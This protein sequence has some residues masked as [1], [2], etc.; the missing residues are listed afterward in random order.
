MKK[1][2]L[3]A[4]LVCVIGY[5]CKTV[6]LTGRKQF[7]LIPDADITAMSS[8]QYKQ[9]IQ[10]GP[11]STN[12]EYTARVKRV[13]NKIK[14]AVEQYLTENGHADLLNG[15]QWE[16]NVIAEPTVNA[17]A[18]PGG[19]VAFY[20]GIMPV[21]A[22][23]AGVA[24]VMGNEVAHAIASHGNE[25]MTQGMAQQMGGVALAVALQEK[26]AETQAL[27]MTAYGV[28]SHYGGILPFSRL[29]ESEADQLGI[30]FMAIAGYDP[31]EAPKF[32]ERMGALSSGQ[33]PPEMMS[34]H[35]SDERRIRDLNTHLP[36]ALKYY[37]EGN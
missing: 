16:F 21:C 15:F 34:T 6:P 11:L 27:F 31:R 24:V 8:D 23:D 22:D 13:G 18:M 1:T 30:I 2:A 4:L 29:Q 14:T 5:S 35:P 3:L 7:A 25:R 36:E 20:E 32:W 37:N 26:P 28:G 17:W 10:T 12:T 33:A 19:K 9:V